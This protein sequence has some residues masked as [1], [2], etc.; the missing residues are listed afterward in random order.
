MRHDV[1]IDQRVLRTLRLTA[2]AA[3]IA[4]DRWCDAWGLRLA[5][6]PFVPVYAAADLLAGLNAPLVEL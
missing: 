5:Q 2:R 3:P 1:T 4:D 6:E